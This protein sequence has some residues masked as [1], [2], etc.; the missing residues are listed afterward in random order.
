MSYSDEERIER[1]L[2]SIP[3]RATTAE[4][5]AIYDEILR[6]PE[7]LTWSGLSDRIVY[8][9][10]CATEEVGRLLC[11]AHTKVYR[12]MSRLVLRALAKLEIGG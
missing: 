3:F 6:Q 4:A 9:D 7:W 10:F 1:N 12:D 2:W 5:R 11:E 8:G